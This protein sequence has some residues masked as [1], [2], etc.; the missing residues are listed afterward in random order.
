MA[1]ILFVVIASFLFGTLVNGPSTDPSSVVSSGANKGDNLVPGSGGDGTSATQRLRR[2]TASKFRGSGDSDENAGARDIGAPDTDI[3]SP[4]RDFAR[5]V[6]AQ[7]LALYGEVNHPQVS[8]G[9]WIY[10]EPSAEPRGTRTLFSTMQGTCE[11]QKSNP[12]GWSLLA[13]TIDSSSL[14]PQY[15]LVFE[16]KERNKS[17]CNRVTTTP[18][19]VESAWTHVAFSFG[20]SP[21]SDVVLYVNGIPLTSSPVTFQQSDFS[22]PYGLP[23]PADNAAAPTGALYIGSHSPSALE[24]R[25]F[26]SPTELYGRIAY[27]FVLNTPLTE[28]QVDSA[29]RLTSA[30]GWVELSKAI[31]SRALALLYL[32]QN[33]RMERDIPELI[34]FNH[35][36]VLASDNETNTA[37]I[38]MLVGSLSFKPGGTGTPSANAIGDA[39]NSK[40]NG[41]NGATRPGGVLSPFV[42]HAELHT[43]P[44]D[45]VRRAGVSGT[46]SEG[47]FDYTDGGNRW[48]RKTMQLP[49]NYV[50]GSTQ[51]PRSLAAGTFS[52]EYT[53]VEQEKSDEL[54][55]QRAAVIKQGMRHVWSNYKQHAWGADELKPLSKQR[56]NNWSGMGMTLIDSLSTLWI[57]GMKEEFNDA[58]DW[59]RDNLSFDKPSYVSVFETNIRALGGLLSAY[60][61]SHDKVFLEKAEDLGNRLLPAFESPTGFPR[62]TVNLRTGQSM[63]FGWT[64]GSCILSEMGTMQVE[65]RYLSKATGNP[66]YADKAEHVI[67]RL[68]DMQFNDDLYPIYF[69]T[70]SGRATT[71]TVT[72]GALGDSF[73]EYLVKTW[74]QGGKKEQMF[75]DFYDD[76]TEGMTNV[77]LQKTTPS[78]LTYVS[79]WTGTTNKHKM[80]HL[81]CFVPGMLA[82]GAFTSRGT[83]GEQHA[84]R[85]L[86][87]AKAIAYTC[88]QFY[89]RQA[90]GISP[91]Y[92][93][94]P[95]KNDPIV[96]SDAPFYILR[97]EAAE[98]LY[99]LHQLTGNPIYREWGWQ[100]WQNIDKHT[101]TQYG[102]ASINDVRQV[103]ATQNDRME[104]YV[105]IAQ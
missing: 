1:L 35:S 19:I 82:L 98:S 7:S 81:V 29:M 16:W 39:N 28:R 76:T 75:R 93:Q 73:Y 15:S 46:P 18:V 11:N 105:S 42:Y 77:L 48:V 13:V 41:A 91:E 78:G 62:S 67:K 71:S 69:N 4:P 84:V 43:L 94:F 31:D 47:A 58:R 96:P 56:N 14:S 34:L 10:L 23:N 38:S 63:N 3:M 68:R 55:R 52:D 92:L 104:R 60:D 64:G 87:N 25:V 66:V 49:K 102:F 101:R 6:S 51:D 20:I 36:T 88:W 86:I 79:D 27:V 89:E 100:M 72:Y 21:K 99:I 33:T 8:G 12:Y 2:W 65:F 50:T 44:P 80:D 5:F 45:T 83:K 9:A 70:E 61:L 53:Q 57:M 26:P 74:I 95:N 103:P 85:D 97:P 37:T 32:G 30:K 59:I 22:S 24:Q 90:T 17:R 40:T 54:G